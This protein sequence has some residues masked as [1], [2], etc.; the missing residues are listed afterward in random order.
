MLLGAY[1]LEAGAETQLK[2]ICAK[3]RGA[4]E[5]ALAEE[6]EKS[7]EEENEHARRLERVF[8]AH[9]INWKEQH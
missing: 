9:G 5:E 2:E 8:D 3:V 1:R 4:G 7:I 6:I